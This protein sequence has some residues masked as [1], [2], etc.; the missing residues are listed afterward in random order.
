MTK[1]KYHSISLERLRVPINDKHRWNAN[2]TSNQLNCLSLDDIGEVTAYKDTD[3]TADA[4]SGNRCVY[5]YADPDGIVSSGDQL[6][7]D[8]QE[9]EEQGVEDDFAEQSSTFDTE[10]TDDS[11]IPKG[12]R[13]FDALVSK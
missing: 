10:L 9:E 13:D 11:T 6:P 8:D 12:M 5:S 2:T 1:R 3:D 4:D 7:T